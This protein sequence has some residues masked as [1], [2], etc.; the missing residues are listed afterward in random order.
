MRRV[1]VVTTKR[2]SRIAKIKIDYS[3]YYK[4]NYYIIEDCHHYINKT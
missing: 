4:T 2:K 3:Y 1:I